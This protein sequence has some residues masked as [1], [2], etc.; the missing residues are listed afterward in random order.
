MGIPRHCIRMARDVMKFVS[1][2]VFSIGLD[3]ALRNV[4]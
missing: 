3:E 4:T 2:E 1:S